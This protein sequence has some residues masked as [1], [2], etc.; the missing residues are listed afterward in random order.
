ME[1]SYQTLINAYHKIGEKEKAIELAFL[2]K[3]KDKDLFI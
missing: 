3:E 1:Q 2:Y